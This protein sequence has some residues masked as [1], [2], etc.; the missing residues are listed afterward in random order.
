MQ[1]VTVVV[2]CAVLTGCSAPGLWVFESAGTAPTTGAGAK[3]DPAAYAD[4]IWASKVVPTVS[5]KAVDAATLLPAI[6]KDPAA[7]GSTYGIASTSGG[8]PT[9]MV[10]GAGKVVKVD[11]ADPH[12]PV[13]VDLGSGLKVQIATGPVITGT[14]IRDAMGIGFGEFANQIAYQNVGTALNNKSKTEVIAQLDLKSLEGKTL[15]FEGAFSASSV[16]E[17]L[18]VPTKLTVA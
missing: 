17:V 9:Y 5:E 15:T 10:K 2:S 14:A 12:G 7:A 13:T 16:D 6:A 4:S 18:V 11:T 1:F 3:V 8:S